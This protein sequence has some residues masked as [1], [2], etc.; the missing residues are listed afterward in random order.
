[1]L[2]GVLLELCILSTSKVNLEWVET[3]DSAHSWQ[4]DSA[5]SLGNPVSGIIT[6]YPTQSYYLDAELTSPYP[7]LLMPSASLWSDKYQ[8]YKSMV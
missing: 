7:I 8:F 1:M 4:L 5:V 2:V 3:C 6:Q